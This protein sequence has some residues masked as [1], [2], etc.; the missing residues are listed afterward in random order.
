MTLPADPAGTMPSTDPHRS[1]ASPPSTPLRSIILHLRWSR[2]L[3]PLSLVRP[4]TA[5]MAV[6]RIATR[7]PGAAHGRRRP[8]HLAARLR[9]MRT[10]SPLPSR[11]CRTR[12]LAASAVLGLTLGQGACATGEGNDDEGGTAT[13]TA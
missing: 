9:R 4:P 7:P 12:A 5:R 2:G 11:P 6:P 3:T 10:T 13:T 1:S 8:A